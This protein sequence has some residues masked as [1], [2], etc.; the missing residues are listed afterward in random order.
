MPK[1]LKIFKT[2]LWNVAKNP[3]AIIIALGL[4][5]LPALYAW[6]N[7]DANWDPYKNTQNI[8]VAVCSEDEG[9][10]LEGNELNLGDSIVKELHG[11]D[12]IGWEFVD[13]SGLEEGVNAGEYYAGIV[14]PKDFSSKFMS[15]V[16]DKIEK[17]SLE[18]FVND[19]ANAIA[20]KITDA[21]MTALHSQINETFTKTVSSILLGTSKKVGDH[22]QENDVLE[23]VSEMLTNAS[24]GLD[25]AILTTDLLMAQ[26]QPLKDG[27]DLISS[28]LGN[29]DSVL[30]NTQSSIQEGQ[31]Y[32]ANGENI[33]STITDGIVNNL[34]SLKDSVDTFA[35]DIQNLIDNIRSGAPLSAS[36]INLVAQKASRLSTQS[37]NNSLHIGSVNSQLASPIPGLS[38]MQD[39]L[40]SIA[41]NLDGTAT[42]IEAIN[43]GTAQD[44]IIA[45]LESL[46]TKV[47]T[48]SNN[49][50]TLIS[51][52]ETEVKSELA[53]MLSSLSGNLGTM[54]TV[55]SDTSIGL[56]QIKSTLD[57]TKAILSST[58]SSISIARDILIRNKDKITELNTKIIEESQSEDMHSLS[59]LLANNPALAS[60]FFSN[61]VN[62]NK[63]LVYPI[64]VYGAAM[65]PFYIVLCFWVGCMF[66][67]SLI[68]TEVKDDVYDTK[69]KTYQAY[70]GR[71][72][73]YLVLSVS[74]ALVASIGTLVLLKVP[75]AEPLLFVLTC[76][77]ISV[78]FTSIVYAIVASLGS[79][80][81]AIVVVM[82]VFQVAGSGGTFPVEMTSQ[83][84]AFLNPFMPFTYAINAVRECVG[85]IY[86]PNFNFDI[87]ALFVLIPL[88]TI[89]GLALHKQLLL[90]KTFIK[91][92]VEE[93]DL[94]I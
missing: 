70:F 72:L 10:T 46:K 68:K 12:K 80:G 89:M 8:S 83:I 76:V 35:S 63:Q 25:D 5:V 45:A 37:N 31:T 54:S 65:T 39:E 92:K 64:E 75:V 43:A 56:S 47:E 19:K 26:Q 60:D 62:V 78:V 66:L 69:Y 27:I 13:R 57:G 36:E 71:G 50:N 48:Q 38:N 42:E 2:D 18:Y 52:Y 59:K 30:T 44:N 3:F 9:T 74:Q 21:G 34:R 87:I 91:K 29:L 79:V 73:T 61:P 41:T 23:N 1:I 94:I 14:I 88:S 90:V 67:M 17:P 86:A 58:N 6:L 4:I 51:H 33:A 81:K 77:F 28:S 16:S 20:P 93:T 24:E 15:V 40:H 55:L 11:N 84:F 49:I 85:G 22:L 32:I 7:I 82:L 53:N